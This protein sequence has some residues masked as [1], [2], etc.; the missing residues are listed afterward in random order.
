LLWMPD[1]GCSP[2]Q[3]LLAEAQRVLQVEATHVRPPQEVQIR[4]SIGFS[5]EK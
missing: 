4:R 2:V 3:T 1:A 5:A